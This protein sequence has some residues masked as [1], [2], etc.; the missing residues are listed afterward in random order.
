MSKSNK[1]AIERAE[2]QA[3]LISE[4]AKYAVKPSVLAV[5]QALR[6]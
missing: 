3:L 5:R 4:R 2:K 6:G 1:K